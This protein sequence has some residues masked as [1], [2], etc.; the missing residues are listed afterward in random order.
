M[1][2]LKQSWKGSEWTRDQ[3]FQAGPG[4]QGGLPI[5]G[6]AV[7]SCW[8]SSSPAAWPDGCW[9]SPSPRS[10]PVLFVTGDR[11]SLV[12]SHGQ[13]RNPALLSS[14]VSGKWK[15]CMR[16]C[17]CTVFQAARV[18]N[19]RCWTFITER[20]QRSWRNR[21]HLKQTS[22]LSFFLLSNWPKRKSKWQSLCRSETN[23]EQWFHCCFTKI[24]ARIKVLMQQRLYLQRI[25]SF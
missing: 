17:S 22:K 8:P 3:S 15:H 18:V 19:Q 11:K 21:P 4:Q 6:P 10:C 25:S 7:L 9:S 13:K 24:G 1:T 2:K 14:P 16:S 5:A 20:T 12:T 23:T